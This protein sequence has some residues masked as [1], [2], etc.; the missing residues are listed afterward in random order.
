MSSGLRSTVLGQGNEYPELNT[1]RLREAR[2]YFYSTLFFGEQNYGSVLEGNYE[3]F[4][5]NGWGKPHLVFDYLKFLKVLITTLQSNLRPKRVLFLGC[6]PGRLLASYLVL[7][8]AIGVEEV[9][10]NDYLK[11]HLEKAQSVL[12]GLF[13]TSDSNNFIKINWVAGDCLQEDLLGCY[14]LIFSQWYV[15]SEIFTFGF[16]EALSASRVALGGRIRNLLNPEGFFAEEVPDIGTPGT[17]YQIAKA[18]TEI[19]LEESGLARVCGQ[20]I[21][22]LLLSYFGTASGMTDQAL[23]YHVRYTPRLEIW[24]ARRRQCG[25]GLFSIPYRGPLLVCKD[26]GT[27]SEEFVLGLVKN[28]IPVQ[29]GDVDT[30]QQMF[31]GIRRMVTL[32]P[33]RIG[34]PKWQLLAL[35]RFSD[36]R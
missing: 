24:E 23:P 29:Q 30:L 4:D 35:W 9:T 14:D 5:L 22:D 34:Y 18:K 13:K 31:Q 19:I 10:F 26:S 21:K 27:C 12:N 16:E 15:T 25:L 33:Q 8:H 20:E 1:D 2:D 7:L 17:F 11:S 6:G 32:K 36:Q 28:L 3:C